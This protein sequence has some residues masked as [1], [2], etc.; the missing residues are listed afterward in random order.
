MDASSI[1]CHI[2]F[3][4]FL[5]LEAKAQNYLVLEILEGHASLTKNIA[6]LEKTCKD[7]V[8]VIIHNPHIIMVAA[9]ACFI[10]VTLEHILFP[11]R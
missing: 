3:D 4:H 1:F 11:R 5:K 2:W 10:Y 7:N 8:H 9:A 6:L